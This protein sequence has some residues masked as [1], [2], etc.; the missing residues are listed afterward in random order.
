VRGWNTTSRPR[1]AS[2]LDPE[3]LREF[4]ADGRDRQRFYE[5]DD[6]LAVS[7]VRLPV[8]D[9]TANL[10]GAAANRIYEIRTRIVHA[11]SQ[12]DDPLPEPLLPYDPEAALLKHDTR[13]ARFLARSVLEAS[14]RLLRG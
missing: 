4:L 9:G 2:L 10:R 14:A 8:A 1:S 13:L 12:H 3:R 7:S 11:K 5:S 6:S